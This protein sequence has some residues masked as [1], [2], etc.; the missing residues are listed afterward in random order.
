MIEFRS[1]HDFLELL[2]ASAPLPAPGAEP[3]A[4]LEPTDII[5]STHPTIVETATRLTHGLDTPFAR[6]AAVFA[7]VR[8]AVR[9]N[10]TPD[11]LSRADWR[12]SET[13]ARGD[14]FCQQKAVLLAALARAVGVPS[15][16]GFQHLRDYKLLDTR[17]EGVLPDGLIPFHGLT[18]L[19]LDG[20]W[21]VADA[22]LDAE[23]CTHRRYRLVELLPD[24]DARLPT[25]DLDGEPHF[26]ILAEFGPFPD[27]PESVS[28]FMVSLRP[29][30]LALREVARRTGAT[31]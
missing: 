20:G 28:A 26:D 1:V 9:Y 27:L 4:C 8:D 23:L 18:Y 19:W 13:L 12:A 17:Y 15:A 31:M 3:T 21:R 30:W 2:E 10:F 25:T 6:A 11:L 16:I 29:A 7:F 5:E 14:G 24:T 22:T